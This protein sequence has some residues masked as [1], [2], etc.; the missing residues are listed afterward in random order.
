MKI[1]KA[2]LKQIIKEER[3]KLLNESNDAHEWHRRA[4]RENPPPPPTDQERIERKAL[5]I[6]QRIY[7]PQYKED[8]SPEALKYIEQFVNILLNPP[9]SMQAIKSA[10][11]DLK[12]IMNDRQRLRGSNVRYNI[13]QLML[14][15]D[16][17]Q[18]ETPDR[19]GKTK[20]SAGQ[21]V[22]ILAEP[23]DTYG[24]QYTEIKLLGVFL[25][26]PTARAALEQINNGYGSTADVFAVPVGKVDPTG[27][28]S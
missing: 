13:D 8:I 21:Q 24:G 22:Y 16:K 26:E 25:N 19:Q 7:L 18:S 10:T 14:M 6:K 17:Q 3:A 28:A 23:S 27:Y 5:D 12:N 1:T 20:D 9:V 15:L 11:A 2:K 4:N